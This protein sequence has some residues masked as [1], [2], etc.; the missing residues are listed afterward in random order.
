MLVSVRTTRAGSPNT[1][2]ASKSSASKHDTGF[3]RRE[4]HHGTRDHSVSGQPN[5]FAGPANGNSF[6]ESWTGM[7]CGPV[8]SLV[9][10]LTDGVSTASI[11]RTGEVHYAMG[12]TE[13]L[14]HVARGLDIDWD[15][16]TRY[17]GL[18]AES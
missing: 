3:K 15:E 12:L 8:T 4:G 14:P 18:N 5:R 16:A 7:F 1:K 13:L 11:R 2:A 10:A 17:V 9:C 6:S